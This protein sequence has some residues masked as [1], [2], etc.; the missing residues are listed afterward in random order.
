MLISLMPDERLLGRRS[1]ERR[2]F[3]LSESARV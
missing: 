3:G 1:M 2:R